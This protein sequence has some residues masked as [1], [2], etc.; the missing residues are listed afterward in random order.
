MSNEEKMR[1]ALC[2]AKAWLD[3]LDIEPRPDSP[4]GEFKKAY[5]ALNG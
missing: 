5:E 1:H 4:A 2:K 3:A